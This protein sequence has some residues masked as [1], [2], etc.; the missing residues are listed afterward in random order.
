MTSQFS[1]EMRTHCDVEE[2]LKGD[3]VEVLGKRWPSE[4]F[5]TF[6]LLDVRRKQEEGSVQICVSTLCLWK[7]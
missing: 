6:A 4:Q 1:V 5:N 7:N 3:L 2:E